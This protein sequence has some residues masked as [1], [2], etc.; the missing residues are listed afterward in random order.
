[1]IWLAIAAL[2]SAA[3]PAVM[4]L[5]NLPW[6]MATP[7]TIDPDRQR[8]PV[9]VLIPARDEQSGIAAAI[10][11]ATASV[12]VEVEVVVLD[13]HS[14]DDTPKI[15]AEKSA[16]DARVRSQTSEPLPPGWNGKQYACRQLADL[17]RYHTIV[18]IDADVRLS[19]DGLARMVDY[20]DQHDV[21]L[22][23]AFPNQVT[24]TVLEKAIIP[25]MH[26]IL[27]CFLPIDRMRQSTLPAYASGCGQL[28]M[29]DKTAYAAAGTHAALKGSRHD[30]LKLPRAYRLS[31]QSTDVIDGGTIATC[32]MYTSAGEVI[33]GAL[34]NAIEGIANPRVIVPFTVMLL[35]A[36]VLPVVALIASMWT[37]DTL[38]I[39]LS[40]VAILISHL[41]RF[42]A[43]RKLD[44][45]YLGAALT[46]PATWLF[47]KL[48][49]IA[50]ANYFTGRQIAWRGRTETAG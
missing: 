12:G 40:V 7:V 21:A 36:T 19:P 30:G 11:A 23:S 20:R 43:A 45:S 42:I 22:L 31:D 2:L 9:S 47:V 5:R 18:F 48:Q 14:T 50:L 15:L 16:A 1:M 49:W 10:D 46:I 8:S 25:M 26:Y 3:F 6:F 41:P 29:T 39:I 32:R 28:F 13:D 17:A 38:A 34:K 24:G 35:G 44:Q 33:N 37:G 27:L 4:F